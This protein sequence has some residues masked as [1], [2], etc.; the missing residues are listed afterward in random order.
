M[1]PCLCFSLSLEAKELERNHLLTLVNP[2]NV[3]P[4]EI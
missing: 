3:P 1:R 2:R 4:S